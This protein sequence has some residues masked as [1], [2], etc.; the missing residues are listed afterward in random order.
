MTQG[1]KDN[2][3]CGDPSAASHGLA[4]VLAPLGW[5]GE[6]PLAPG[7]PVPTVATMRRRELR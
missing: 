2:P 6:A 4:W 1:V 5:N 3:I 7:R